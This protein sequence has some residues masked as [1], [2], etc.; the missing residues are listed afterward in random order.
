M[1]RRRNRTP[2]ACLIVSEWMESHG[3]HGDI[4]PCF[5]GELLKQFHN[6]IVY[7]LY[8]HVFHQVF[9]FYKQSRL[10]RAL[11]DPWITNFEIAQS[12]SSTS[13][14]MQQFRA[15][16]E[17]HISSSS[18]RTP[19]SGPLFLNCWHPQHVLCSKCLHVNITPGVQDQSL[20]S[21]RAD[22]YAGRGV[23][24][25]LNPT[26]VQSGGDPC[27]FFLLIYDVISESNGSGS[28]RWLAE[29]RW[30]S[31]VPAVKNHVWYW[32]V[33]TLFPLKNCVIKPGGR[34]FV[35]NADY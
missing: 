16:D 6:S 34:I 24:F 18:T 23:L 3:V 30:E 9:F 22:R 32:R 17:T 21:E 12:S 27:V 7:R 19:G 8:S 1:T 29:S 15:A 31:N 10:N 25:I 20:W 14:P 26:D 33:A 2:T 4:L 5:S 11:H 13:S 28:R 35:I